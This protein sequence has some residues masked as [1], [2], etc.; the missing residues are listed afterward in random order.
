MF[1]YNCTVFDH[2]FDHYH[3]QRPHDQNPEYCVWYYWVPYHLKIM[4]NPCIPSIFCTDP[5]MFW[6][7]ACKH[8]DKMDLREGWR[9]QIRWIFGNVSN[10]LRP[11]LIF[12]KLY[13]NFFYNGYGCIIIYARR[14]DGQIVW[15][16]CT[17]FPEICVIHGNTK[18]LLKKHTRNP[19]SWNYSLVSIH[20]QKPC[21][22][23]PK[24]AI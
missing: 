12:G 3:Q 13:C 23:S 22:K 11:P 24:S 2:D 10:G 16:A 17:W 6:R 5:I 9:Y 19:E 4:H 14:Y 8:S 18:L 1:L 15:N 7:N 20:A 21:L